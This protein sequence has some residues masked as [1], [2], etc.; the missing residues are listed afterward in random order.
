MFVICVLVMFV[1]LCGGCLICCGLIGFG[2]CMVGCWFWWL[3]GLLGGLVWIYG[4]VLVIAA[5]CYGCCFVGFAFD[6]GL[7]CLIVL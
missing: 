5:C 7:C 1:A 4:G 2:Y 3:L 6:C